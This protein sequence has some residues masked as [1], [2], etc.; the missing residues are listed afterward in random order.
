MMNF[1]AA[2][3][4]KDKS[5]ITALGFL[6]VGIIG[7]ADSVTG[8]E[9]AFS[10]FYILPIWAI[11]WFTGR[12]LGFLASLTS[13]GALLGADWATGHPYSHPFLPIWNTL[14]RLTFFVIITALLASLKSALQREQALARTDHLTGA[15]NSRF[16]YWLL[17]METGRLQR[18]ERPFTLAYIDLDNFKSVNDRFGHTTGDKV[19]RRVVSFLTEH[20]RHTDVVARVGGDEFA[21]LFPE[22]GLDSAKEVVSRVRDDLLREMD[23]NCWPVT[24]SIGVITYNVAPTS[25]DEL[26]KLADDE[27]YAVKR[28]SKNSVNYATYSG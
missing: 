26:V 5:F 11:T 23:K 2:I 13:A 7:V 25:I 4:K 19:L 6:M 15:A 16:F 8:Y 12:Q 17:E 3:E 27:M 22:T 14:I 21:V 1:L 10:I 28:S 20:L 24:F 9:F 18:Y